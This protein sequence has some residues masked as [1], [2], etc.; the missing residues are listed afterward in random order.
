MA[1]TIYTFWE[2]SPVVKIC[3]SMRDGE[4]YFLDEPNVMHNGSE[5][6]IAD[7]V[8]D[9]DTVNITFTILLQLVASPQCLESLYNYHKPKYTY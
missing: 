8:L 2:A 5:Y 4:I 1:Y 6:Y 7:L 9:D 3:S